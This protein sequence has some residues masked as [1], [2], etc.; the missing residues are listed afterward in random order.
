MHDKYKEQERNGC[1]YFYPIVKIIGRHVKT[2]VRIEL[3]E[4]IGKLY[5]AF[6]KEIYDETQGD[7]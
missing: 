6:V 2:Q 4:H 1:V 7:K 3:L 5:V